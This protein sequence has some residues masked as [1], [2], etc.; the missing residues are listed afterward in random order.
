MKARYAK[1]AAGLLVSAVALYFLLSGIDPDALARSW[2]RVSAAGLLLAISVLFLDYALRVVR[3]WLMLRSLEARVRVRDCV[4]PFVS[5][6]ALNNVLPFRAGDA[7]RA[8]G[9]RR[10]LGLS[11][12]AV[13][14]TVLLERLLDLCM[15]L[16]VFFG[17]LALAPAGALPAGA[18]RGAAVLGAAALLALVALPIAGPALARWLD[19]RVREGANVRALRPPS[20]IGE[21]AATFLRSFG[22]LRS[23]AQMFMLVALSVVIW[24]LEGAV[25]AVVALDLGSGTPIAAS[26]FSMALGTLATLLPSTPGYVGTFD[27][28]AMTGLAAFGASREVATAFALAVHA[29]LWA[30][31]TAVGLSILLV[32]G[33]VRAFQPVRPGVQ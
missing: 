21:G 2:S 30:P 22:F 19:S 25:F 9:F 24:V 26:W 14:G 1:F 12:S 8:F 23:P 32:H 18:A 31:L 7:I 5:S 3:W 17:G 33:G 28:F 29:V 10:Q 16:M 20:R 11:G 4:T 6:I 13:L 27:Y 15:L